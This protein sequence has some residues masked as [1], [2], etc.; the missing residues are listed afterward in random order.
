MVLLVVLGAG[1]LAARIAVGAHITDDAYI[2]MRYSRNLSAAGM[3]SYNPPD[4]VL[5]T[6]SPLWTV[7]LVGGAAAGASLETT[8]VVVSFLADLTS[9][10]LILTSP[11][12]ASLAAISAAATIAAWPAYVT[13]AVS[14]M[15]TSFYVMAIVWFVTAASRSRIVAAA[16]AASLASLA[17]PDGALLVVL[18]VAWLW[19]VN[20]K[21]D[22]F[23]F[24]SVAA[25]TCLPWTAYAV[26]RFGSLIPASVVAKSAARDPWMLSLEN[27]YAYFFSGIYVW[28]SVLALVGFVTLIRSGA[29]FWGIWSIWA[30]SYLASMTI[31][32]GFTH[33]PWYFVPLLPIYT[34]AA[35]LGV[36]R[37]IARAGSVKRIM[38]APLARAAFATFVVAVLL[39]RMPTLRNYL[40]STASG[41]ETLYASVA[42][43]L[44]AI[45]PHC[46]VAAT[47][48]GTI[49]YYYPGRLLDLVGL[50]SP[51]VLGRPLDSVLAESD[52]RWVVSYDTHFDRR[53]ATSEAFAT[54]F[55][56]RRSIRV[57]DARR[58]EVY[59]RRTPFVCR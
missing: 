53:V 23:T 51:E 3:M 45:D 54:I 12:G 36:E 16:I 15:E 55:E 32:N 43:E 56:R 38:D 18:G 2:T 39:S 4:A 47:E 9:I 59:E 20:S 5:G 28:L 34:A 42:T 29:E 24:G 25:L 58:L 14:G 19:S 30:W 50:V 8:A 31:A 11:V 17:R 49:G 10:A 21:A 48:I 41:R 22:A 6:S 7:V 46:T 40:D 1:A 26:V 35:T 44:A 52:A 13:Y 27:L 37:L 33:F 57:G